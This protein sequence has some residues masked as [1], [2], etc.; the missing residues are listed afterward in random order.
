MIE[1]GCLCGAVRYRAGGPPRVPTNCH[2]PTCRKASGGAFVPWATVPSAS[3]AFSAGEPARFESSPGVAR[4]FCGRCGT[5]LTYQ[6]ADQPDFIDLTICSMDDPARLPPA[7]HTW[8]S[9]KLPWLTIADGL[10]CYEQA[11]PDG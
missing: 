9:L 5:P 4:A 7:D 3:F 6:R 11:R 2:C 1:G 8:T 10:P